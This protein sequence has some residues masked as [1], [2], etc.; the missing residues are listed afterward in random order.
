MSSTLEEKRTNFALWK[1]ENLKREEVW[2]R[3]AQLHRLHT[4]AL[5]IANIEIASLRYVQGMSLYPF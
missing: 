2:A 1:Q 5:E 4:K 3:N